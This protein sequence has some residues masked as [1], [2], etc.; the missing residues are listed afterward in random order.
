[1]RTGPGRTVI[2]AALPVD[3]L[4]DLDREARRRGVEV[5]DLV[6]LLLVGHLPVVLA[7][8]AEAHL[9]TSLAIANG[10]AR[11]SK[12][13]TAPALAE[14]AT[15]LSPLSEVVSS[16]TAWCDQESEPSGHGRTP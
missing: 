2:R 12:A 1:M 11:P 6:D 4:D 15:Q 9:R 3:L 10:H 16:V 13:A 5:A 8:E 7:E 14:A